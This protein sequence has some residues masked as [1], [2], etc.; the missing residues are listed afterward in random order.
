M[1]TTAL[2]ACRNLHKRYGDTRAVDGVGFGTAARGAQRVRS[3]SMSR[4]LRHPRLAGLLPGSPARFAGPIATRWF[5]AAYLVL[6]T[7]RGVVHL[8]APDGG[9]GTIAT[10]DV[11]VEGGANVI[12]MFGQWGSIQLLLAALLWLLLLR[13]R[14]FVPLV[15]LVLLVEPLLRDV[16]GRLK[17]LETL[18]T[19]P[20]AALNWAVVPVLAAMLWWSLCPERDPEP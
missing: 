20:G 12:A 5:A 16:A 8:V 1:T 6:V 15:L 17:P 11:T 7:A 13:Y 4:D 18:G 9:A 3:C 19:A 14:G 2:F 10:I